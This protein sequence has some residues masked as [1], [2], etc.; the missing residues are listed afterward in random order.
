MMHTDIKVKNAAV[1]SMYIVMCQL[2]AESEQQCSFARN[3]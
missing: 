1:S 3:F 2:I